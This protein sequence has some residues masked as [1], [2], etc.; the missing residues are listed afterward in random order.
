[1]TQLRDEILTC[2]EDPFYFID[3]Y[4]QIYDATLSDWI[5]FRLWTEQIEVLDALR[6]HR[7]LI[8]LKARQLGMSWLV[9]ARALWVMIFRSAATVFVFSKRAD[10][11][12]YLLGEERLRGMYRRLPGWLRVPVAGADATMTWALANGSVAHAFPTTAGDSYTATLA[13]VDEA[14]LCP[15]LGRLLRSVKPTIDGGGQL[16]MLSQPDKTKLESEFK[17][18]YRSAKLGQSPWHPIFLPWNARPDRTDAWYAEQRQD[19][20]ERTGSLDDLFEQY[21]A[22][23]TEALSARSL[24]KRFAPAWLDQCYVESRPI[25]PLPIAAPAIA[26]LEVYAVSHPGRRYVIGADPAEGN[27]TSDDSALEVMD[28]NTGEQMTA[29]AGKFQPSTF[30]SLIDQVGRWYNKAPVYVERQNHG[31]A[32]ILWLSDHSPLVLLCGL[33]GRVGWM[34]TSQSKALMWSLTGD[35]LGERYT[36]L[37]SFA[38]RTQLGSI[39]GATLRAPEG[40]MDDRAIAF[41]LCCVALMFARKPR[42]DEETR[43]EVYRV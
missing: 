34:T 32:V 4:C 14:D 21:P 23:D 19:I 31:H 42:D 24:D 12:A 10:E 9:L 27:P 37:H 41:G 43:L 2:A 3:R 29:L 38:T 18:V 11:A 17:R 13:I 30:A 1:M 15:D 28:L 20:F 26:G 39:E 36:T 6:E 7:L 35:A 25:I 22:T 16:I 8:I 33:D 5:P 40:E